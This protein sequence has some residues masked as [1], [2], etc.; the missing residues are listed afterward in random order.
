MKT[1][2]STMAKSWFW[3]SNK[4][5]ELESAE[6]SVIKDVTIT[7]TVLGSGSFGTVYVAEYNGKPCAAKVMHNFLTKLYRDGP[8]PIE[9]YRKEINILSSLRHPSI[10]QFLGVYFE[11][12]SDVPILMME[13]MWKNISALLVEKPNQLPLLIKTHILYDV[14]CGLQYLHG[15]KKPVVHRDLNATNVLLTKNLEAKIADLGQARVLDTIGRQ[16]LTRTPG[17]VS[18]MATEACNIKPKYDSKLDM[19]SFGCTVIHVVTEQFPEP[20]EEFVGTQKWFS[21]VSEVDRRRK[22]IDLMA[23]SSILLQEIALACLQEEPHKRLS[24]SDV[25]SKLKK[26]SEELEVKSPILATQCKENKLYLMR[27]VQSQDDELIKPSYSTTA[28]SWLLPSSKPK[29]LES[30]EV[31]IIKDVTITDTVLGSGAYGTVYAAE[32]NGKPCV[33]KIMHNFVTKTYRDGPTPLELCR[34]EINTLSSLRHPSIVQFLGVYFEDNSD[35]PILM[36]EK[37]WKN[38]ST[39]LAERPNQLP[40][41]IKTHILYDVAC[42][43]Q[44]LHGQKKPVVHRDL[45][46]NN[47]L[48]TKNLEAK[49]ADLGQARVL[50]TI[51]GQMLTRQPGNVSHMAPEACNIKPKYDSK[52]DIFSFGC[53]VIHVVTEQFP[54]PTEEFV[55]TARGQNTF[56]KVPEVDRRRKFIDLMAES[57]TLLQE[58]TLA[59][60]QEEPSKRLNASDVCSKLK[61]HSEV[62]EVKSPILAMQSKEDKLYSMRLVQSQENKLQTTAKQFCEEKEQLEL[63]NQSLQIELTQQKEFIKQ[64]NATHSSL[65]NRLT[66]DLKAKEDKIKSDKIEHSELIKEAQHKLI[67]NR[68]KF[69]TVKDELQKAIDSHKQEVADLTKKAENCKTQLGKL[70]KTLEI[71]CNS[72]VEIFTQK[73]V[74]KENLIVNLNKTLYQYRMSKVGGNLWHFQQLIKENETLRQTI[75]HSCDL[76]DDKVQFH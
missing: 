25:C 65:I 55:E 28:L 68:E 32:Y 61:K 71:K 1:S 38:L 74:E 43:L 24:A 13:K 12:N 21:K 16:T 31:S 27:L 35:V 9:L 14:A 18:H 58:I 22:F 44:Y 54:E 7:D 76:A 75:I 29:Q 36:M 8:S 63:E 41:L 34:K 6:F 40:L 42:G 39:L 64:M 62:L 3:S 50:D 73:F 51:G 4:L 11:D 15:Q 57:S 26:H 49:I 46:A 52:F 30:A 20:T 47:I 59:C 33:A 48:L 60:L 37:M 70:Q 5:K 2:Y 67:D 17:N 10:V 56:T 23:E 66:N 19:F 72:V 45:N 53:T 69:K